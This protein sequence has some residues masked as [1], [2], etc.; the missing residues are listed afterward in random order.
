MSQFVSHAQNNV[1]VSAG[2]LTRFAGGYN[3]WLQNFLIRLQSYCLF[4]QRLLIFS[5]SL[6][7]LHAPCL[8]I[9]LAHQLKPKH[10]SSHDWESGIYF[11]IRINKYPIISTPIS[12]QS[13]SLLW[14]R[15][16]LETWIIHQSLQ[17]KNIPYQD[18]LIK[19]RDHCQSKH[20]WSDI[21]GDIF[22]QQIFFNKAFFNCWSVY[23]PLADCVGFKF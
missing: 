11:L 3:S 19:T 17:R 12:S 22:F 9:V 14:Q 4:S 6:S 2:G 18:L 15:A 5:S 23:N 8:Q 20:I 21:T 16:N 13:L 7:N 10:C 1:W